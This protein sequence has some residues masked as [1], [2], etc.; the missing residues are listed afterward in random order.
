MG[1]QAAAVGLGAGYADEAGTQAQHARDWIKTARAQA[2]RA[3]WSETKEASARVYERA[4]GELEKQAQTQA[5]TGAAARDW[6]GA[7]ADELERRL[8]GDATAE[9]AS[10]MPEAAPRLGRMERDGA[11][12]EA[13][14]LRGIVGWRSVL[15]GMPATGQAVGGDGDAAAAHEDL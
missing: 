9:E 15:M 14:I 13:N 8:Y 7:T 3:G 5:Q 12:V 6:L 10:A 11:T 1:R 2:E 4:I